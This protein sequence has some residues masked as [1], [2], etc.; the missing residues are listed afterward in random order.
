MEDKNKVLLTK[1]CYIFE[2][3]YLVIGALNSNGDDAIRFFS[4]IAFDVYVLY[5]TY[6]YMRYAYRHSGRTVIAVYI[7]ITAV[8]INKLAQNYAIDDVVN[9]SIMF[10]VL[11]VFMNNTLQISEAETIKA[12]NK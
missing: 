5:Q 12:Q 11:S 6:K 3:A 7:I 4:A 8:I 9:T 2:I 1:L 10:Y